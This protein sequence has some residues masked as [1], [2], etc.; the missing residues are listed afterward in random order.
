VCYL[1]GYFGFHMF[2]VVIMFYFVYSLDAGYKLRGFRHF[3]RLKKLK[4]RY[5]LSDTSTSSAHAGGFDREARAVASEESASWF[6]YLMYIL[7]DWRLCR[8]HNLVF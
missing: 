4:S 5:S 7:V 6:N 2:W 8:V 3:Y 1:L